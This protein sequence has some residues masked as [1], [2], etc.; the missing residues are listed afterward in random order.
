[1][2]F[3]RAVCGA[4]ERLYKKYQNTNVTVAITTKIRLNQA[5]PSGSQKNTVKQVG[6]GDRLSVLS[7]KKG[8]S[9]GDR[10]RDSSVRGWCS[11]HYTTLAVIRKRC[12]D[13]QGVRPVRTMMRII[14]MHLKTGV[15]ASCKTTQDVERAADGDTDVYCEKS[16][17]R[18]AATDSW[19]FSGYK[20]CGFSKGGENRVRENTV[21]TEAASDTPVTA[22]GTV[23]R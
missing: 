8:A 17:S 4:S 12:V 9:A 14:A 18:S 16:G 7:R 20:N 13:L 1:M 19:D 5:K 23:L 15:C 6:V 11:N 21:Q 10:T 22:L 3:P 2:H